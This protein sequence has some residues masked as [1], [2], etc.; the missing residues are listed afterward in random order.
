MGFYILEGCNVENESLSGFFAEHHCLYREYP[1]GIVIPVDKPY[2]WTSADVVRKIKFQIQKHFKQKIKV[3]YARHARSVG[4]RPA[5][6]MRSKATKV[7]KSCNPTKR[8]M[9]L[10]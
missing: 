8:S 4:N 5:D 7:L 3:G 9:W 6:R 1:E 2:R 10:Q